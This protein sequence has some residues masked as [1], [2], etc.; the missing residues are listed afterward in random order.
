MS[1]FDFVYGV[2][3][4]GARLAGLNAWVAKIELSRKRVVALDR[5]GDLAGDD[6]RGISLAYL[7]DSIL[8][9]KRAL[10]GMDFPF[11]L[12][13]E[14]VEP[15]WGFTDQLRWLRQHADNAY[16][17]GR[18]LCEVAVSRG[19]SMHV[20]RETDRET[21]TPFDCYHYRIVCQ[22]FY[23]MRDVLGA[24]HHSPGTAVLPF[25]L[26]PVAFDRA[27]V[28][29]CPGSTLKRWGV[30][31]NN[32]KQPA[33]GPLEPKRIKNRR[34][35]LDRLKQSVEIDAT[36]V[37][38]IQRNGGGDALDAVLAAVG[39]WESWQTSDFGA[40]ARHPRYAREGRIFA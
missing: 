7:A 35:I 21:K 39:S 6:A 31:H 4:S 25:D 33:G 32:Y 18:S 10:W 40:I 16:D 29:A 13:L 3:F 9:S 37:R 8:Q 1:A 19:H 12:P 5:L 23:G 11:A 26:L 22:T 27:V 36:F 38:R 30:P 15:A 34:I 2:D 24:V 20:R 17:F 28:E 14:V